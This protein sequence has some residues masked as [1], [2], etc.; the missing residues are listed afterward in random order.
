MPAVGT[1]FV[2]LILGVVAVRAAVH[3][4]TLRRA[5]HPRDWSGRHGGGPPSTTGRRRGLLIVVGVGWLL[6]L[7]GAIDQCA[8]MNRLP[9]SSCRM[10]GNSLVMLFGRLLLAAGL[11][12]TAY[13]VTARRTR[14]CVAQPP[15]SLV[16]PA[17]SGRTALVWLLVTARVGARSR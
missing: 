13:L 12:L 1:W 8:D 7:Q 11:A 17:S 5:I 2:G 3:V 9:N 4:R 14:V 16:R 15:N 6:A 10:G